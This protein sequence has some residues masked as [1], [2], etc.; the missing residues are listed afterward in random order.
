MFKKGQNDKKKKITSKFKIHD[1][2][3]ENFTRNHITKDAPTLNTKL[4]FV[5][6]T[7]F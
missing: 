4:C 7:K 2:L 6:L 5:Y 3:A 1:I